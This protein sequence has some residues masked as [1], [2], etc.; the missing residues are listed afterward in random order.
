MTVA[1]SIAVASNTL[2]APANRGTRPEAIWLPEGA[3]TNRLH[4]NPM[5]ITISRP[6]MTRSNICW[7]RRLW[8]DSSISDTTAVMTPPSS[9][10]RS[11]NR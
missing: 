10:G 2:S 7:L 8:M 5:A 4:M 11:N 6:T 3:P 1:P 9:R